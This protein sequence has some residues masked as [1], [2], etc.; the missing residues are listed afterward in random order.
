MRRLALIALALLGAATWWVTSSAGADDSHSYRIEMYNAFGIVDGSDVRI[1][2]VNAGSVT[3]LDVNA[4]KRAVVTV[5][6]SGPLSVLGKDT[7]CAS[8]PQSLIAEYFIDCT[9]KGPPLPDNAEIPASRVRMTVQNDLVLN[10]LRTSYRDRLGM[11]IN[12]F[13]TALAGNAQSLN[14]AI[15]LGSPALF[16]LRRVLDI[17]ARQNATIRDLNVNSDRIIGQLADNRANVIKFIKTAGRTAAASAA[18]REDLSVDFDRLDNFLAQLGPTTAQLRQTAI[19]STPLLTDLHAAAPGL[20]TLAV[21]LPPF[22]RSANSSLHALGQAAGPGRKVVKQGRDEIQAL[23]RAGV[24]AQPVADTLAKF[25]LDLDSP[26]RAINVDARAANSCPAGTP[27]PRTQ[28]CYSTGRPAP[29]GYDGL[30]SLLNY[31]YYQTGALNQFDQIGHLLHVSLYDAVTGPCGNFSS[32]HDP[33]TGA[34]G[35]PAKNGGKTTDITQTAPCV[36]WLGANQ[37]GINE[38]LHLPPY[39][40]SV[41]PNGTTPAAALVYCNPAGTATKTSSK[42]GAP[43]TSA[44]TARRGGAPGGPTESASSA[45][46]AGT[47]ASAR[48]GS[49]PPAGSSAGAG[50]QGPVPNLPP[51]VL[52]QSQDALHHLEHILGLPPGSLGNAGGAAGGGSSN[53]N[54]GGSAG[55]LGGIPG[56]GGASQPPAPS[57][58]AAGATQNLLDYLLGG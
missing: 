37:P 34:P 11:L 7:H 22:N 41:C 12:E 29:T 45:G 43:S 10:T 35:V 16:N 28:P 21:N 4:K 15:R 55:G 54:A 6:L 39:D 2:G 9:P 38:D 24:S 33:T 49:A 13:G 58:G 51:G 48:G 50:G 53:G 3:G 57:S 40:P 52:P 25:L 8:E 23:K 47:G 27:H 44:K 1:G 56:G 20:N 26:S 18:Q 36:S 31:V 5:S 30:E 17:L 46:G 42:T 19:Q 32:G 14:Q